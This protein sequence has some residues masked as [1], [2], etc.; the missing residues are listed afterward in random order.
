MAIGCARDRVDCGRGFAM[1][2]A[3][4]TEF[5]W[6]ATRA[7]DNAVILGIA[8]TRRDLATL[9]L[10][11]LATQRSVESIVDVVVWTSGGGWGFEGK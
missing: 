2:A 6:V 10:A 7:S 5:D 11:E 8:A 3:Q 9:A 4:N 1:V